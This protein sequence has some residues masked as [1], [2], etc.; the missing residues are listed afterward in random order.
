M[1]PTARPT[2]Q[3]LKAQLVVRDLEQ[4]YGID[5]NDTFSPMVRWS[6]LRTLIALATSLNWSIEHLDVV[7]TFLNG[8][9]KE[10][11]YMEQTKGYEV[12][13]QESLVCKL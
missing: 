2:H 10:D 3:R 7:T 4:K 5:F 8:L 11:I 1:K 12:E 13:G 6:T 9:L